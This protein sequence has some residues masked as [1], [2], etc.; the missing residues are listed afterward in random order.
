MNLLWLAPRIQEEILGMEKK[1]R[2]LT[3][4]SLRKAGHWNLPPDHA[5]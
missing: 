3:E 4:R 1:A 5:S 2:R